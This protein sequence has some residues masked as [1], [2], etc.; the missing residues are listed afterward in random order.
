MS[1]NRKV[2][3]KLTMKNRLATMC[4]LALF[5]FGSGCVTVVDYGYRETY[6][7]SFIRSA[8]T[9]A[10]E[11]SQQT[12]EEKLTQIIRV[13]LVGKDFRELRGTPSFWT[14]RGASVGIYREK[15]GDLILAISALGSEESVR[16]A[17]S[18]EQE[19]IAIL[20]QHAESEVTRIKSATSTQRD[21]RDCLIRL[22]SA[23]R[24]R[25]RY[26]AVI[27]FNVKQEVSGV[28][29]PKSVVQAVR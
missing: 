19:L 11:P 14:K 22:S 21:S 23:F 17:E 16:I 1:K 29:M 13:A 3:W 26:R 6:I 5:L 28:L 8:T 27:R 25:V 20:K 12:K 7:V 18:T 9:D 10:S 15:N 24:L 4:T 2:N